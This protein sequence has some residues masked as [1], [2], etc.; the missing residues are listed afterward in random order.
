M[1]IV[2]RKP[3]A[4]GLRE[5]AE[6][7]RD[8]QDDAA[9]MH[10]HPGDVG[11][12][13]RFGAEATIATVRTWSRDGR[14]IAV[15]LLDGDDL[16]RLTAAAGSQQDEQLASQLAHDVMDPERGVLPGG[17]VSAEAPLGA[18]VH[19]VLFEHGWLIDEPWTPLQRDLA[20]PAQASPG[21]LSR[22]ACTGIIAGTDSAPRSPSP[23]QRRSSV[24]A[25][26]ALSCAPRAPTS[27]P[28]PPM[29][30]QASSNSPRGA[31]DTGMPDH[32]I[33]GRFT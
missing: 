4:D 17:R 32:D 15:G 29:R 33:H 26:R 22:W 11:W 5:A 13:W 1:G 6:A 27:A 31:T 24:W 9:P 7:L 30:P 21:C 28:S 10:L 25:H 8:W 3:D 23:Q 14:I 16:L 2:L 12:F 18:L 20:Q 19:D